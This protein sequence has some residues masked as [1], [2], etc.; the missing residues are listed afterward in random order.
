MT[1]STRA[2]VRALAS[3]PGYGDAPA[4]RTL[5]LAVTT[6]GLT[7]W[8]FAHVPY[9]SQSI[10]AATTA[11]HH[12]GYALTTLPSVTD[13][14]LWPG[15]NVAGAVLVDSPA[16]DPIAAAL[17]ARGIPLT[18][19]GRPAESR[20]GEA[21]VDNDHTAAT[22][23]VLEHLATQGARRVTL[24]AG[25]GEEHYTRT[26]IAAYSNWCRGHGHTPQV[27]PHT[28]PQALSARLDAVL[29]S[30]DRP[31]AVFGIYDY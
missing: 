6:Y 1:P 31:D 21:W 13:Q 30:R 28:Y 17:R 9:F 24:L 20:P 18:F 23:L 26:C 14:D 15:L 10:I 12:H 3:A 19:D 8:N 25:P 2:R 11:A 4:P 22:H 16:G 7:D 27:V 29:S 5:G